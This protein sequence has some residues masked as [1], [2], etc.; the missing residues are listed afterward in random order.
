MSYHRQ[1]T[2]ER[3][4]VFS[5]SI[6]NTLLTQNSLLAL[7]QI[8]FQPIQP[9]DKPFLEQVYASSRE[10]ELKIVDWNEEQKAEFLAKADS[11]AGI[12][13][14]AALCQRQ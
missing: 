3:A 5:P 13:S 8:S 1:Q 6:A 12:F 11:L 4:K 10:E 7:R 9:Q 2:L 14:S